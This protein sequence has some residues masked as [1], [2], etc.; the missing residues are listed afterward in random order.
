MNK[1]GFTLIEVMIG[2]VILAIG[3]LAIAGMQI[4]STRGNFSSKN[5]TQATYVAQDRLEFLKNF[6]LTSAQLQAGN[7]NDGSVTISGV[8]FNRSYTVV[9]NGNLT[10]ITY[11]ATWNNGTNHYVTLSTVRSQ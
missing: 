4:A 8:V 1:K 10:T 5:L 2:L 11:T 7:Y 6:P 9:S 3:L